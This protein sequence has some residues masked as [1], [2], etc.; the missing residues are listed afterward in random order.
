VLGVGLAGLAVELRH[1]RLRAA[2]VLADLDLRVLA[3]LFALAVALGTLATSWSDPGTVMA[4]AT[5]WQTAALGAVAAVTV[6]NLPAA[7]LLSARAPAHPRALLIGLNLG[8]NLAV[9]GSLSSLLWYRAAKT[10]GCRPSPATVTRLG[11]IVV[12]LSILAALV[13]SAHFA[14]V[15]L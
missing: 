1:R 15:H 11:V 12:P 9:T 14:P 4:T 7:V 6:N 8:P 5:R 10:V 13:A 2:Q 3:A